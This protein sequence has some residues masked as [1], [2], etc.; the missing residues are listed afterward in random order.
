[1]ERNELCV[2]DGS[3][4]TRVMWDP[5]SNEEVEA[6]KATFD[7]LRGK[8]YLA[9]TVKP[10]GDPDVQIH[11]FNAQAGKIVMSPPLVGG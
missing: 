3:G 2:M 8:G 9:F 7:R 1:M 10:N 6:A 4:D 11:A 5:R